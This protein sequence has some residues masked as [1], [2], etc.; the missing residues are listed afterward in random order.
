MWTFADNMPVIMDINGDGDIDILAPDINGGVSL[1]YYQNQAVDSGYSPDS[2]VFT[3]GNGCSDLLWGDF[4]EDVNDCGVALSVAC[5]KE[6]PSNGGIINTP[7]HQGGACCGFHYRNDNV[8]SLLVA[9]ILCPTTKFLENGGDSSYAN[10]IYCDS[11]FPHYDIPVYCPIAPCAYTIDGNNDGYQDLV[12]APFADNINQEGQSQDVNVVLYYENI[13]VDSV[14]LF[15]YV[16][17]TMITGGIDI[18]TESHAVFFDYNGDSLS[19][20][21][22]GNYGQF[23]QTGFPTS[24]LALYQNI[25]TSTAPKYQETSLNWNNLTAYQ[26]NGIYP[27]F[28][29]LDG[30]GHPDMLIGDS[31]G[32]ISFFHNTGTTTATY[33]TMTQS[34]WFGI[35][36][37]ANAAPF[38]YDVNGDG[39]NDIIIG[40]RAGSVYYY[41]NYGTPTSPYFSTS[42]DSVNASF[43]NIHIYDHTVAGPPPGYATPFITVENGQMVLYSG[44][45]LGWIYKYSINPDSLM[46]GSF[47][48]LD[49]S[50]LGTK[51]GL[52]STISV[53]DI[54]HDGLN[55][56]LC[57]NIRGGINLYSDANWG[58]VPVI[59]SINEPALNQNF[60]QVYPNPAKDKIICRISNNNIT[61]VSAKLLD[62]LGETTTIT[63]NRS[64]DNSLVLSVTDVINGIYVIQAMDSHGQLYQSKISIFK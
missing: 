30:D 39:L 58:N 59:S 10:I 55:D 3:L 25:G 22:I 7:R 33:P 46:N 48:L 53:A 52:R 64:A 16:S 51:P 9:D 15:H 28:G 31:Y 38:I 34:D 56:Y 14:N 4:L 47:A 60:M 41:Q 50:V 61:L 57:G 18:G 5:K 37:G 23:S 54:N 29:D 35:N 1:D 21:V 17:D 32:N 27:A 43:G 20:I 8:V 44:S 45:Q 12:F 40:N 62:M 13:G 49:T 63:V 19:D 6:L 26:L 24:Y 11:I 42:P 2:L 36:V